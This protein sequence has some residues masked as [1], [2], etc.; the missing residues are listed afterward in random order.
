VVGVAARC[1]LKTGDM[2]EMP[3]DGATFDVVVSSL[4]IHNIV[5]RAGRA[6]AIEEITRV[7]KPGGRIAI[8]DLAWTHTYEQELIPLGLRDVRRSRLGW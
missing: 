1:E 2:R 3:F 6:R 7:L 4:A 8:A 5:D